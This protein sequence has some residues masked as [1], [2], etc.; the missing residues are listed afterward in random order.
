MFKKNQNEL[1]ECKQSYDLLTP[2]NCEIVEKINH[3]REA[4]FKEIIK[5]N[6][7]D[8]LEK[9]SAPITKPIEKP[10]NEP[11]VPAVKDS[12][13]TETGKKQQEDITM[14]INTSIEFKRESLKLPGKV[15][16]IDTFVNQ[17]GK[18][19]LIKSF[20]PN[21]NRTKTMVNDMYSIFKIEQEQLKLQF[22]LPAKALKQ[23]RYDT[24]ETGCKLLEM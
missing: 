14:R 19:L 1:H 23:D 22:M 24:E 13:K 16:V 11:I 15:E 2:H 20:L 7:Q 12:R 6:V 9:T 21:K 4:A 5:V 3:K 17:N 18:F 8:R 10:K